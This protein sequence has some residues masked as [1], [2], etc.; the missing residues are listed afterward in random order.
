LAILNLRSSVPATIVKFTKN[1]IFSDEV[2]LSSYARLTAATAPIIG[3]K[4]TAK[5]ASSNRIQVQITTQFQK[6]VSLLN[7]KS[8][9]ASLKNMTA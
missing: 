4:S 6:I 9:I 2:L 5:S 3:M 8:F 7:E 1:K